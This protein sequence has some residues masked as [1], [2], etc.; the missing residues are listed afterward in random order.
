MTTSAPDQT[1]CGC[2]DFRASRRTFL[3][4]T[5]ATG[6]TLVTTGMVGDVFTQ[7][8]YGGAADCNVLVVLS[9]RGG[10]DGLSMVVPHGDT[11]YSTARPHIAVPTSELLG[12]DPMFGLHPAFAPLLPMWDAGR[13]AAVH[14]VGLP[15]PNRSHFAAMEAVEDAD[16][17]SAERVGWINRMVGL[18]GTGSP[19]SAVGLGRAVLPSSLYGPAPSLA[20][21]ELKSLRLVGSPDPVWFKRHN[22][23]LDTVWGG[24]GGQLGL[25]ARSALSTGQTLRNLSITTAAPRNGARYPQG[26]LG[27]TLAEAA[28][29]IHAGVGTRVVTVDYGGWDMHTNLGPVG[30]GQMRSR[31]DEMSQ[32][33][34]AFFTDLGAL[35]DRVTVVTLS[36]F[37]RRVQENG[38]DGLD[39][40]H[41]NCV[42]VLGGGVHGGRYY[43]TWPGLGTD[44]LVSGD[45]AVTTDYRS[46]IW[47]IVRARFP[48]ASLSALFPS[49]VP[50]AIGFMRATTSVTA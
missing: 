15:Q 20:A 41:G 7:V 21:T 44:K 39:H 32:T 33:L 43:G 10:A 3:K 18:L 22:A 17:S 27:V 16:P 4:G 23:A 34:A 26:D 37:G 38:G 9:L 45:L 28:T 35:G 42:L 47:E 25:G 48:E 5:I 46:V 36:E 19:T 13:L 31:V 11:A 29:L 1:T 49:F 6:A 30:R 50:E 12:A 2:P 40:G 8:A 24:V 14:A